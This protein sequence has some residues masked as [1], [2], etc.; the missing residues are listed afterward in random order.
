MR[1]GR[2]PWENGLSQG[3]KATKSNVHIRAKY[4]ML[5]LEDARPLIT[6]HYGMCSAAFSHDRKLTNDSTGRNSSFLQ[7][8]LSLLSITRREG[9][10]PEEL[11]GPLG[12]NL[13]YEP[14]DPHLDLVFVHGLRGGSRKTWSH[15]GDP[16]LYWPK[17]WLPADPSVKNTRIHSYGYNSDWGERKASVLNIHD[18]AQNLLGELL[19]SP[20]IRSNGNSPIVFISHSMGGLVSK[21]AYLL[22]K[23]DPI[24]H[25]LAARFHTMIFLG[26]PHRG[27]SSAQLLNSILRTSISH[28]PKLYVSDL[29]PDSGALQSINDEFRHVHEGLTLYSFFETVPTNLGISN[30]LIVQKD[31]AFASPLDRNYLTVLNAL[32]STI[33]RIE[34]YWQSTQKDEYRSQMR[35]ISEFLHVF[36]RPETDLTSLLEQRLEGTCQWLTSNE[37]YEN[38]QYGSENSPRC[39]WLIGKPATGKST[40]IAHTI[41]QLEAYNYDC[42]YFFFKDGD[43]TRSTIAQLLRSLAYQMALTN[44]KIREELLS[45]IREGETFDKDNSSTIWRTL[46]MTRI[47]RVEIQQPHFWVIDAMDECSHHS[48]LFSMI[49]KVD[50]KFPLRILFSS[51]PSSSIAR[52]L[53]QEKILYSSLETS[54][55]ESKADIKLLLEAKTV[56]LTKD[57]ESRKELSEK[58]LNMSDGC[59]LWVVLV[60]K[61][62]ETT[63]GEHQIED[64]LRGVPT[65][66]DDL[67]TKILDSIASDAKNKAIVKAILRWVICAA[68]PLTIEEL[69]E[70]LHFDIQETFPTLEKSIGALCGHLVSVDAKK[71]VQV[72]HQTL[73]TFLNR[74]D[75]QSEFKVDKSKEQFRVAE[76]CLEYLGGKDLRTSRFRRG[77]ARVRQPKRSVF[78]SYATI[79]F[80]D[81]V[82]MSTSAADSQLILIETFLKTNILTW[83]EVVAR[84]GSLLPL[85]RTAK[86]LKSYLDRRAKYRSPLGTAF[87]DIDAWTNDLIRVVPAFGKSLLSSPTSIHFLIPSVCPP[88]SMLHRHFGN[89]PRCMKVV[90]PSEKNWDDR[91]SCIIFPG[92]KATALACR[93]GRLAVGLKSGLVMLYHTTSCEMSGRFEHGEP[94]R[95][96][97]FATKNTLMISLG[98]RKLIFWNAV[99]GT[100]IWQCQIRHEIMT[101]RFNEDDTVVRAATKDNYIISWNVSDGSQLP[102]LSF[103]DYDDLSPPD[104][105]Q[106]PPLYADIS[107][108]FNLLAV[109]YRQRPISFWDLED[110]SYVGQFNKSTPFVYPGPL[111]VA[112]LFNP[113][114]DIYLVAAS[115]HD[116]DLVVFDPWDQ[117][118][119]AVTKAE[120]HT[121]AASPDGRT[122]ATGD[123]NGTLQLFDFESLQL[124][125]RLTAY[126]HDIRAIAFTSNSLRYFDIR[127]DH[128]NIW[129]PSVLVSQLNDGEGTNSEPHSDEVSQSAQISG[130]TIWEDSLIITALAEH[131][132]GEFVFAGRENGSINVFDTNTGKVT[133]ELTGHVKDVSI[134]LMNWNAKKNLL[135]STDISSRFIV[136]KVVKTG[137]AK[138]EAQPPLLSGRASQAVSQIL[139]SRDGER[140]LVSTSNTDECWNM[141]GTR[142]NDRPKPQTKGAKWI[143]HPDNSERIILLDG[144]CARIFEWDTFQELSSS[145]GI[146]LDTGMEYQ[147]APSDIISSYHG[148]NVCVRFL[149][150]GE[151]YSRSELRVWPSESMSPNTESLKSVAS[152]KDIGRGIKAI[153]GSFKSLVIFLNFDG[154]ICSLDI[155]GTSRKKAYTKHFL[156][157]YGWHSTGAELI[158]KCTVQGHIILAR[159]DEIAVFQRGLDFEES[160]AL[161]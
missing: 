101:L 158:F 129:E 68:R 126:D 17:E 111:L 49:S 1:A 113:N 133:D 72:I 70:A 138:W 95:L 130:A 147:M 136:R 35:S 153:V 27:A 143:N 42:S 46:F 137:S 118:K 19:N 65:G 63:Y 99:L 6:K 122:L 154:W 50:K 119:V 127:G 156:I 110:G 98:R 31:S 82:N 11:N 77:S 54:I 30:D 131:H 64:L 155:E 13:L 14:S 88:E 117:K 73:R 28:G 152:Y 151:P 60:L 76:V 114:P 43:K 16:T 48:G 61:E 37:S 81:H 69:S 157:P 45:M 4:S 58:I 92:T 150:I 36:D 24:Y 62:L 52:F 34:K 106:R 161:D 25:D 10:S 57:E 23:R 44:A 100:K 20:H 12:L 7:R 80:S 116:G 51:R 141:N 121:L 15:S 160:I 21:K 123:G 83:I 115:Y 142:I 135:A 96:I 97:E 124:M 125:Y 90:G 41:E 132:E 145:T 120:A 86:N 84:S 94:V 67:Y 33:D 91:L 89:Y 38:W 78:A 144:V 148:R 75:L 102:N 40:L 9:E 139:M 71:R 85:T 2:P 79:H 47:F 66:M 146:L 55:N 3:L 134:L 18:F 149:G 59:F 29:A 5:I 109:A 87:R 159:R 112:L 22:A 103:H 56:F 105:Y 107:V 74:E 26:T 53:S 93:D 104:G 128:C 32:T 140:L 108:G 8:R 39:F